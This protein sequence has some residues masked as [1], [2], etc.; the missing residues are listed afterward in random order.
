[1]KYSFFCDITPCSPWKVNKYFGGNCRHHLKG[2]RR[3]EAR[4]RLKQVTSKVLLISCLVYSSTLKIEATCSSEMSV[5]F[6]L[7]TWFDIQESKTLR[8]TYVPKLWS[9]C[10]MQSYVFVHC[11]WFS[12]S[13][14]SSLA[15]LK[16]K[17]HIRFSIHIGNYTAITTRTSYQFE[18]AQSYYRTI[19]DKRTESLNSSLRKVIH[20]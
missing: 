18:N 12:L 13:N 10:T 14:S 1:M 17:K 11:I 16:I 3:S 5:Y 7:T 9:T 19:L 4:N 15:L 2:R 8:F 6:W 20:C